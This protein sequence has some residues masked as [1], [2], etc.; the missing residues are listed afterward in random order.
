MELLRQRSWIF[1]PSQTMKAVQLSIIALLFVHADAGAQASFDRKTINIG[2]IGLSVTNAGTVGRPDIVND[3][4]GEPSMEY[5]LNSGI[6]HLFEGGLWI[7][8]LVNGQTAVSTASV[9][10]PTG[11]TTGASGFEF[12]AA[13]GNQIQQ[14]STL[15]YSDYFSVNAVSHQDMLIDF[16]DANTIVPGTIT[17]IADHVLPLG[18]AVH[19]ECYAYN[20][21]FADYFV[22]LNYTITNQSANT[23][24][25]VWLGTW[26][27]LVVRNVNVATDNGSAFFSKGG[28]G[29]IDSLAALYAF[30]VNGDPGYTNSYGASQFLGM[31]WRNQFIHPANAANVIA[32]GF[33]EPRV[34]ANFWNFKAFD[35]SQYGAP[36]DDLQR[37][38][39]MKQ[40]LD[41]SD[42]GIVAF[43]QNPSNR[44]Q[45]L[46]AGPLTEVLP[47]ESFTYVMAMV[48]ARQLPTGG[49]SGPEKD[50]EYAR[51]ELFDHLDWAKRTYLGEDANEN[52]IL[53]PGED[54]IPNGK[55]DRYI[56]PE[57]PATPKVRIV[58][59][60]NKVEIYW[61][62]RAEFSVDPI[63]REM[64][65]EG[66][67][68]YRSNPG[69]DVK[70]ISS[71]N[72][73]AQWDEAGNAIGYNNGFE[74]IRLST[75]VYFD[76][77][78]TAYYYK[79]VMDNLLNGWQYVFI[80]TAFDQGNTAL[81]LGSLESSFTANTFRVWAGTGVNN[82][83]S[84]NQSTKVGVYP[85][86]Y[87]ASAAWDGPSS[88]TKK[89]YFYNLP[90]QCE[91]RI[92]TLAGDV[93]A[94]LHHDAAEY[95]GS[96]IQW[97]DTYG[98]NADQRILPGGEHAWDILSATKQSVTQGIYLFSVKDLSN[99]IVQEGQ[100][101]V[102]K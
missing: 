71:Q 17:P 29:F 94:T 75:P 68:I 4:Q 27:D 40:G 61:D 85:N 30:D 50:T 80:I 53:D 82:F 39:K 48:C 97:F 20:Y 64:D 49:T 12:T 6:E 91:I 18:A 65:F 67:R 42:P 26:T 1:L 13:I 15:S 22:I 34:N 38:E 60:S 93:V 54:I 96:D 95:S 74:A 3:P 88:E 25:S 7:G 44:V 99:N 23:W 33:P 62:N 78:T 43:L 84:K 45:L 66:Y 86:P 51:T 11:Y 5:P 47:G 9:D 31:E 102:I 101:V 56:L 90:A 83:I 36:E 28:G 58:P 8:A 69:D 57:P 70:Q 32:A 59:S 14:R 19:L 63:S 35:G 16:T 73:I 92:Y 52:G 37:Y 87:R 89:I 10:A 2:N 98:G 55:L 21:S 24:D 46:S 41:F 79:F 76:D 77:D 100:F 81:G 72:L